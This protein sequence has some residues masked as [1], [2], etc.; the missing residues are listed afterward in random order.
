MAGRKRPLARSS[1]LAATVEVAA[2]SCDEAK[3]PKRQLSVLTFE[4]WQRNY[5]REHQ[6]LTWLKCERDKGDR[7]LV[8]YLWCS[9]CREHSQTI[10][11]MKHY[12]DVWVTGSKNH[13]TSNVMDHVTSDQHKAAMSHL[14][15][16]QAKASDQ[17]VL[18]YAPIAC[19]L[20]MLE[21][22]DRGRMRRKLR[23]NMQG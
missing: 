19:Y 11:S 15:K 3:K 4:K 17:S 2:S 22:S 7:G 5:D 23:M 20:V 13:R 10:C 18:S 9:A 1:S 6:T 16:A 8:D 12:S 21:E 14:C